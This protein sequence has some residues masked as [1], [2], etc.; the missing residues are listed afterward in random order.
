VKKFSV[1]LVFVVFLALIS[2]VTANIYSKVSNNKTSIVSPVPDF[3]TIFLNREVSSLNLWTPSLGNKVLTELQAPN[4]SAGSALIYDTTSKQVLYSKDPKQRLP[5]AS[6]TKVMTAVI[7]LENKKKDDRYRVLQ[8]DLIGEDSMGLTAGET[9]TLSD[10]LYGIMLN[11]GNDAAETL[12]TNFPKGRNAFIKA[13]NDKIKTL[14]LSD[15]NFTNPSGLEG[16]GK[17]YTTVYD[18]LVITQYALTNFPLFDQ[19]VSTFDYNIPYSSLHKA[20]YLENQT[21]LLTSYPGVKGVKTGYT[22]EAGLCLITYLDYD[23][24]KIIGVIL[25]S[26]DRRGEMIELLDYSL[27]TLGITP[28]HH[29]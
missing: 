23:G 22:P 10:L 14:G 26:D 5:M 6:L 15:T 7:A 21:N 8:E 29:G 19:V 1:F 17:Q 11:S 27:E 16:D 9:L 2:F 28:P 13:M 12:A 25:G 20:F 18:L 24:H 4:I 3:L